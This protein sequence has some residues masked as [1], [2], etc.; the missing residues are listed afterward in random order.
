ME[1][2]E[3]RI[4]GLEAKMDCLIAEM[5]KLTES[6][7]TRVMNI[8]EV[9]SYLGVSPKAIYHKKYLLPNFGDTVTTGV[10][11]EWSKKEI[12]DW[13]LAM[14]IEERKKQYFNRGMATA[15]RVLATR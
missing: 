6:E 2:N 12:D 4:I 10:K 5:K 9:A 15:R 8:K 13:I 1:I 11:A 7:N 14:P 3:A